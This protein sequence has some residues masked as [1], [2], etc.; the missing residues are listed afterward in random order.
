MNPL[1]LDEVSAYANENMEGFHRKRIVLLEELKLDNLLKK[2]PYLF[3]VISALYP[4]F[5]SKGSVTF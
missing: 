4:I 3:K 2:N 1:C 5:F